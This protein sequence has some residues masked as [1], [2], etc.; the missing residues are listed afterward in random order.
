MSDTN[1]RDAQVDF[2]TSDK[3]IGNKQITSKPLKL[4]QLC[5]YSPLLKFLMLCRLWFINRRV[6]PQ[7]LQRQGRDNG[8]SLSGF[9]DY[10]SHTQLVGLLG[11][12]GVFEQLHIWFHNREYSGLYSY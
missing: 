3:L 4:S 10:S 2:P 9:P 5:G 6:P 7:L 8:L 12:H 11:L 1:A